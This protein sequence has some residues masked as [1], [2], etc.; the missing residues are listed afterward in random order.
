V[1]ES[2]VRLTL[3]FADTETESISQFIVSAITLSTTYPSEGMIAITAVSPFSIMSLDGETVQPVVQETST[4]QY[5]LV[6]GSTH[7]AVNNKM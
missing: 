2:I 6:T 5:S 3:L 4:W 1:S 7:P